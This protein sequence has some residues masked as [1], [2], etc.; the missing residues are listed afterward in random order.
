MAVTDLTFLNSFAGG[1]SEKI[2]KYVNL[3]IQHAPGMVESMDGH[4]SNKDY[5]ALKTT[6][7]ALK[8][9]IT[10]MGIKTA[11]DLIREIEQNA[12]ENKN[13]ESIPQQISKLKTILAS[14]YSELKQVVEN[15]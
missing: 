12:G 9:Q 13:L 10:Y 15:P 5:A 4:L 11:E 6:A 1:N 8:P 3:F 14:A 7:H 2:N